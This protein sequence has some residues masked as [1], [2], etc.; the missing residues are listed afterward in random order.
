MISDNI[1]TGV[2]MPARGFITRL[3]HANSDAAKNIMQQ[4]Q[5]VSSPNTTVS[6]WK[7]YVHHATD[8]TGR[9][10]RGRG[11]HTLAMTNK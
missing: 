9:D 5:V 10:S 8:I 2:L 7:V 4:Q 1:H 11:S 3:Y 6:G